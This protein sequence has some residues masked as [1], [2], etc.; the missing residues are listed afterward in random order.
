M[1]QARPNLFDMERVLGL[2]TK[3]R[4]LHCAAHDETVSGFGRDDAVLADDEKAA[5]GYLFPEVDRFD[6]E[7]FS[8]LA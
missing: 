6:A 3:C 8:G 4:S 2:R 7:E 5:S 1:T